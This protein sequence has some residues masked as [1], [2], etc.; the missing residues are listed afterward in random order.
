MS[1]EAF[2]AACNT[3]KASRWEIFKAKLFGSKVCAFDDAGGL[4]TIVTGYRWRGKLY[5]TDVQY[6]PLPQKSE[7]VK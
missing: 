1:G 5:M 7:E 3:L 2:S 6:L 4:R